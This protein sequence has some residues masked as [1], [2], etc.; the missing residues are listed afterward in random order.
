M[1]VFNLATWNVNSLKVRLPQVLDYM[2]NEAV[3]VLCLQETKLTDDAFPEQAFIDA[4]L[5]VCFTGQKTYNGV[6]IISLLPQ[7]DVLKNIPHFEDEQQRLISATINGVRVVCAYMVNGQDLDSEKFIYKMNWLTAL[8]HHLKAELIQYEKLALLGDFNIAPEDRDVH[9]P[10]KWVGG[11]LVSPQERGF[12]K[13]FLEL[14]LSD[15]FRL[16]EQADQSFSWWDYRQMGFRRNAGLRIDH[17][18]LSNALVKQC[19][20]CVIDKEPR[21]HEQP[22]DHTVVLA[23]LDLVD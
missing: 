21:R 15:A 3:D 8:E 22:S 12:F 19:T 20:R 6:A 7:S 23:S 18:L 2:A 14:G 17:V 4:G 9:D 1:T 11:N 10:A 5:H 16:F 13:A